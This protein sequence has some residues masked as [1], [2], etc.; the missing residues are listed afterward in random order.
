[1]DSS[2]LSKPALTVLSWNAEGLSKVKEEL[3]AMQCRTH[4]ADILCLQ[5]THRGPKNTRPKISNMKMAIER[6][7]EKYGSAIFVKEDIYID[8][9][10]K[11]EENDIEQ[12]S[13]TIN[14]ITVTSIYKPPAA[15]AVIG[16]P[17]DPKCI[18]IGDFNSHSVQWGYQED[19]DNGQRVLTWAQNNDLQLIHDPKLPK[20]F[21]SA[22]WKRGYNP[23]LVFCGSA[24]APNCNKFVAQP[25][26]KSQHRPIGAKIVAAVVPR[27]MH[28][29]RRFNFT[30]ADWDA[31]SSHIDEELANMPPNPA[32]YN[33]FIDIV[34]KISRQYIPRGCRTKYIPGLNTDTKE[35]LKK[36]NE[37]YG[38]DPFSE[39]TITL[40]EELTKSIAIQQRQIWQEMIETTDFRHS[41]RKS[42]AMIKRLGNDNTKTKEHYNVTANQVATQLLLN[43][44]GPKKRRQHRARN[45]PPAND[46]NLSY[47]TRPIEL[48]EL[49]KGIDSL[50]K[51]KAAG[52]DD[53]R[54]EQL[55]HLGP[56]AQRW[57]LNMFNHCLEHGNIP[58]IWRRTKVVATLKPGKNPS[59]PKSFRPIS[60]LCHT[61]KLLERIILNRIADL[62]DDQ[63]NE[64]QAEG[65][66]TT[67]QLLNLTQHIEDGF[68]RK[69]ITGTVFV[70]LTAAYD[71]VNHRRL[72]SKVFQLTNDLKLTGIIQMMLENRSFYVE[73]DGKKSRWRKQK[74]GLPQ[75]G[76]LAPILYNIYTADI[77]VARNTRNFI[78]A[79]DLCIATQAKVFDEVER[80]LTDALVGLSEY[81]EENQLRANPSKTQVSAFHLKN[82]QA[83]KHLQIEWNGVEL[84]HMEHPIYL[85]V[86]LDRTLTYKQHIRNTKHKVESRN[87]I[88]SKLA[89]TKYGANPRTIRTAALALSFSVAEYA[90]PVWERS[91]HTKILDTTINTTCRK[92]TGCLRP[93]NIQDLYNIAGINQPD[94]RRKIA[95]ST[96]RIKQSQDRRHMLYGQIPATRRLKSRYSFLD[97]V[98]LQACPSPN[99]VNGYELQW[100]DWLCLNRLRTGVGRCK[101]NMAKWGYGDPED[102]MCECGETETM[103]HIL[104]CGEPCTKDD[105]YEVNDRAMKK[106]QNWS[107]RL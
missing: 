26:P 10:N 1:M 89:T 74:N 15:T 93:T 20:S 67:G 58:R 4:N 104:E 75:G 53:I 90:C 29:R 56:I 13:V 49:Q 99:L 64:E 43:G 36:Y 77:P 7:H 6:Q 106:I 81:Y 100:K 70:D 54:T 68:Q 24:F 52:L 73:L 27:E 66:S 39:D 31:F 87:A 11:K 37:S 14:N 101:S 22:R 83:K 19:D 48:E 18:Y 85:G 21:S 80:N 94:M 60:L 35:T 51:N 105:L 25:I 46:E 12:L 40:G 57:L 103:D 69:L 34:K 42:W 44:K 84:Q 47:Y 9:T 23:D 97:T 38:Q 92:I 59:D 79:D 62:V 32:N 78:Y 65:K 72:L 82:K 45:K 33:G 91:R 95:T 63:L 98:E 76:V 8:H 71:T 88:I 28:F 107:G 17:K 3:I 102:T 50:K 5:E 61:Y 2:K 55:K 86:Q 41:S 16:T 30:K 96:E